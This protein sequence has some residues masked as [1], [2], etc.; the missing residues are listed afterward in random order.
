M[1]RVAIASFYTIE[2]IDASAVIDDALF[3]VDTR[4]FAFHGTQATTITF[5]IVELNFEK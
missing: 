4:C 2:A 5:F 3:G 1:H